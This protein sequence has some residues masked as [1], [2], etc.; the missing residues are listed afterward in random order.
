MLY[1][2]I[3]VVVFLFILYF[4]FYHSIRHFRRNFTQICSEIAA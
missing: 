1:V 4:F 2:A 3:V